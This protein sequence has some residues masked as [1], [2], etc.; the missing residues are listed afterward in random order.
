MKL[1]LSVIIIAISTI[2]A[3]TMSI[4]KQGS[5]KLKSIQTTNAKKFPASE[6]IAGA[7]YV[8]AVDFPQNLRFADSGTGS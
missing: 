7:W 3:F 8:E 5:V 1:I 6:K 4:P 2:L